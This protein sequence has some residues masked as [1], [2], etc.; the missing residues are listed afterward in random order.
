MCKKKPFITLL[1]VYKLLSI[2]NIAQNISYNKDTFY[3][4]N[5]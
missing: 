2:L 5:K 3:E 4:L 1:N